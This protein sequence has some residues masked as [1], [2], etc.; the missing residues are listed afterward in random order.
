MSSRL[1]QMFEDENVY[2]LVDDEDEIIKFSEKV[3]SSINSRINN[4]AKILCCHYYLNIRYAFKMLTP[5]GLSNFHKEMYSLSSSD[6]SNPFS[7]LATRQPSLSELDLLLK[8]EWVGI[9]SQLDYIYK[10]LPKGRL[11][12]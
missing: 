1:D 4:I 6:P 5:E 10:C 11:G 7:F 9:K 2:S 3:A 8:E 12:F